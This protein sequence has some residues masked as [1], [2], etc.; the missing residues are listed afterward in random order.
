MHF[1]V[2]PRQHA[3]GV[4]KAH[5]KAALAANLGLE[6]LA[7]TLAA[8]EQLCAGSD[9]AAAQQRG[10]AA[11]TLQ[12]QWPA[13]G[14]V[15][16]A[17]RRGELDDV[18][19]AQLHSAMGAQTPPLVALAHAIDDFDFPLAQSLRHDLL[20]SFETP[21]RIYRRKK[22][23]ISSRIWSTC[24]YRKCPPSTPS[25]C[26]RRSRRPATRRPEK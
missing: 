3:A 6:Q 15:L 21:W 16:Q 23:A 4:L 5:R 11:A 7:A 17:L 10:A 26:A 2:L 9:A 20:Q 1:L 8:L 13:A 22:A 25:G 14:T 24:S 19:Q 18:A 12:A